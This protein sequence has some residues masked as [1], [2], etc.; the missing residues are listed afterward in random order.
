MTVDPAQ[1][2]WSHTLRRRGACVLAPFGLL[3]GLVA[4]SGLPPSGQWPGRAVAVLLTVGVLALVLKPTRGGRD[5]RVRRQPGDWQKRVGLVNLA[6]LAAIVLVVL[7]FAGA[8]VPQLVP[9][10]VCLVVGLHFVPLARLFDQPEYRSTAGGL[11]LGGLAGLAVLAVGPSQEASRVVVGAI[12]AGTLWATSVRLSRR[13]LG[14][15]SG[16]TLR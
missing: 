16:P 8:G 10:V 6:E 4:S 13:G 1:L 2:N 12:A 9:P 15:A 7:A 11:A 5:E 3:W 14:S